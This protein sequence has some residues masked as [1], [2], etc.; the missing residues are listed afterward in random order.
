MARMAWEFLSNTGM[1]LTDPIVSLWQGL[2]NLLPGLIIAILILIIGY[3]VAYVIGHAVRLLLMKVGL[4]KQVEKAKLTKAI[5]NIRLSS[6]FGEIT[7]W[8]IF[9]IFLSAAVDIVELGTLS[10]ILRQL[11]LW[12]PNVI[13][14]ALI[15]IFGLFIAHYVSMKI[16]QHAEM[17]GAKTLSNVTYAVIVVIVT[18]IALEQIGIN[19]SILTNTFLIIVASLGL[20]FALAVGLSFGLGSKQ[21]AGKALAKIKKYF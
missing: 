1:S 17:S 10:M 18:L 13:A 4:E 15:L 19:V 12:I 16:K 6:V 21:E 2:V 7:K 11:V 20:G 14:G 5:G 3:V 9:L 8:Y